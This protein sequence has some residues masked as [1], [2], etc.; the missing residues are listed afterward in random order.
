VARAWKQNLKTKK[1]TT[2]NASG[3]LVEICSPRLNAKDELLRVRAFYLD[4]A[5]WAVE[6]PA[7]WGPWAVPCP[8]SDTEIQRGKDRKHRK[9]LDGPTNP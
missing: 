8:I 5:Q 7:R 3:E 9:G 1:R 2:T 6:D 4:I